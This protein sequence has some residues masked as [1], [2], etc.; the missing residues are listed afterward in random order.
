MNI[1]L[2]ILVISLAF[3]SFSNFCLSHS[4]HT[5]FQSTFSNEIIV[6]DN[7]YEIEQNEY[8]N[9]TYC[10]DVTYYNPNTGRRSKYKLTVV[11]K[12]NEIIQIDFPNGG[13]LDDS[14]FKNALLN[15]EGFT[16][17][18]AISGYKYTVQIIGKASECFT[19]NV[20]QAKQCKGTTKNGTR[21]KHL[22]DNVNGFCFQHQDQQ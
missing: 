11:V 13:R 22:T 15:K 3:W 7:S 14:D 17:F 20:Q 19:P 4:E 12:S 2:H 8:L 6:N 21:C 10:A 1:K 9:G 16:Q 5:P 18:V